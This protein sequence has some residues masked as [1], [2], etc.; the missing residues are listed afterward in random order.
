M[1]SFHSIS[2]PNEWGAKASKATTAPIAIFNPSFHS[3]SFPNE[4]GVSTFLSKY[5]HMSLDV[6]FHSI[7]FPNEWGAANLIIFSMAT[8]PQFPFN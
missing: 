2:F 5:Y 1:I 7:S 3:I 8:L 4:W 6:G